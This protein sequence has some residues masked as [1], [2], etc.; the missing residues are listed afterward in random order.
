MDTQQ[1]YR[2]RSQRKRKWRTLSINTF[3]SNFTPLKNGR[4]FWFYICCPLTCICCSAGDYPGT[5]NKSRA[6]SVGSGPCAKLPVP[7]EPK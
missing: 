1:N 4:M 6:F 3:D 2:K 5:F 7:S